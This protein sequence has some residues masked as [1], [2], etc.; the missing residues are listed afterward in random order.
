VGDDRRDAI[1]VAVDGEQLVAD[2]PIRLC[3]HELTGIAAVRKAQPDRK[4]PS[5]SSPRGLGGGTVPGSGT[6]FYATALVLL[7]TLSFV[8]VATFA[9]VLQSGIED[10]GYARRIALLRSYYFDRAPELRPY[11]LSVPAPQR[12]HVQGLWAGRSQR[13][14][15]V[16]GL[17]AVVTAVL[18]GSAVGLLAAV[19]SNHSLAAALIAGGF[20][21]VAVLMLLMHV[22][23]AAWL[24][25]GMAPLIAD[26]DPGV[27]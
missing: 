1:V 26:D 2:A 3:R 20:V 11:L 13:F 16:A 23:Q 7:P 9:R 4:M 14:V 19:V 10:L 18:A 6:A 25:G 12:L 24:R 17:V 15:T 8:G 21:G 22:Q 27:V 5:R